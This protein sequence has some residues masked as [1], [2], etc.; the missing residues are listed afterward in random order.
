MIRSLFSFA[1]RLALL[2]AVLSGGLAL[3]ALGVA[4]AAP[5]SA[6]VFNRFEP[7]RGQYFVYLDPLAGVSLERGDPAHDPDALNAAPQPAQL[8]PDGSRAILPRVTE[9]GVDLFISEPG[10]ALT[11]LIPPGEFAAGMRSNTYPLWSPDGQWI[12]FVSTGPQQ[13]GVDLYLVAPDGSDLRRIYADAT[14]VTPLN[15]R[16]I[17]V[18]AEPFS[19]WLALAALAGA[20]GIGWALRS[21]YKPSG[22]VK[23]PSAP[24]SNGR[25]STTASRLSGP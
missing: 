9:D 8:S 3:L 13:E 14:T 20:V 10:G 6:L 2:L 25:T 22:S 19:P 21:L 16:W 1:L 5:S 23:K 7:G 11:R 24:G 12:S 15:L 4:R 17:S 18:T